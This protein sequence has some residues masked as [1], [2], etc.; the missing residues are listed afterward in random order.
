VTLNIRI[1]KET[2]RNKLNE[3]LHFGKFIEFRYAGN[4][5]AQPSAAYEKLVAR[6]KRSHKTVQVSDDDDDDENTVGSPIITARKRTVRYCTF[7]L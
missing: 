5:D 7:C 6:L 2:L 1:R 3:D 4:I